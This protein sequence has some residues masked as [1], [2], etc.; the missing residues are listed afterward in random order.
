MFLI[1]PFPRELE[2]SRGEAEQLAGIE[3][4]MRLR[5]GGISWSYLFL[6]EC[7]KRADFPY[8]GVG[9]SL[10]WKPGYFDTPA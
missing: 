10:R 8:G 2:G 4:Q 7:F 6:V 5:S 1:D 9:L 3:K